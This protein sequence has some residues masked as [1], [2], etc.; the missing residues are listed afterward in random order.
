M[1]VD[2]HATSARLRA[3]RARGARIAIDDFG[4]GYS[5]LAVL[6]DFPVDTLK[7]DRAFVSG[8]GDTNEG[9]A[10]IHSLIQLGKSLGL[11]TVAEGIE[12]MLQ[13]AHLEGEECESGQGFLIAR[14]MPAAQLQA[15]LAAGP[16]HVT[17]A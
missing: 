15:V 11:T 7:I 16:T 17:A 12:D 6:R 2:V 8:I 4:T 5:S 14:P 1:M 10:L 3:I 9:A 13:Y